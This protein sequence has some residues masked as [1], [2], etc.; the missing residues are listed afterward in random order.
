MHKHVE[1][2][3]GSRLALSVL[4]LPRRCA[5]V[6]FPAG[7]GVD[8]RRSEFGKIFVRFFLFLECLLEKF[9]NFRTSK[10]LREATRGAVP[11][12][13]VMFYA[14]SRANQTGVAH[15]WLGI[16]RDQVGTFFDEAFHRLA[17]LPGQFLSKHLR[18]FIQTLDVTLCLFEVILKR[19][20]EFLVG[21]G[22]CHFRQS[23]HELSF[24]VVEIPQLVDEEIFES[25]KFHID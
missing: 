2:Q 14:L 5:F 19:G 8:A 6:L 16:F 10:L 13:L 15:G 17:S 7:V 1:G 22:F 9:G 18:D 12:D 11:R 4:V 23:L 20:L 24:G 25:I 3:S 21:G